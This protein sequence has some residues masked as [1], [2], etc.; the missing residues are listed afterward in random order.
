MEAKWRRTTKTAANESL[1]MI[2][3]MTNQMSNPIVLA[4]GIV[5]TQSCCGP[6]NFED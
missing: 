4:D 1:V 5:W 3:I 6:Q 2:S